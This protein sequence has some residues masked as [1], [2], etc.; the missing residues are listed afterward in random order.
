[1]KYGINP[2]KAHLRPIRRR[3]RDVDICELTYVEPMHV[4]SNQR[5]HRDGDQCEFTLARDYRQDERERN[6]I[7]ITMLQLAKDKNGR[8]TGKEIWLTIKRDDAEA[9]AR[10]ILGEGSA[11]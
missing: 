8:V 10:F 9:M 1:M 6:T 7:S 4:P 3:Y 2:D 5:Y 11:E